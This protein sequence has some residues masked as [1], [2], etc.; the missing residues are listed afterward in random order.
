MAETYVC[1]RF[2]VLEVMHFKD[3]EDPVCDLVLSQIRSSW[4][5]DFIFRKTFISVLLWKGH[6]E[7]LP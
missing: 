7:V 6:F 3:H 1:F 4:L 2:K 5:T